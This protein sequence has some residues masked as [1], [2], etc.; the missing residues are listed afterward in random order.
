MK[1]HKYAALFP[2]MTHEELSNLMGDIIERGFDPAFP[3]VTYQGEILDGRNR[4]EA[5]KR[6]EDQGRPCSPVFVE[7]EGDDPLGFVISANLHR[8][9]LSAN[10]RHMVAA[11]IAN[12]PNGGDRRSDQIAKTQSVS[13]AKAAA[14]LNVGRRGV[15]DAAAIIRYDKVLADEVREGRKKLAEATREMKQATDAAKPARKKAPPK[16]TEHGICPTC[17]QPLPN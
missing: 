4:A 17:G 13:R 3:I 2:M 16:V 9:H 10:Q 12:M 15:D 5:A 1:A 8:R 7:Y 14:M 11:E 6:L